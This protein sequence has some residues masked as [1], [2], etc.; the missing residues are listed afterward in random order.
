MLFNIK[1]YYDI[2]GTIVQRSIYQTKIRS[3]NNLPK[4]DPIRSAYESRRR[5]YS[6]ASLKVALNPDMTVFITLTYDPKRC[7]KDT[8]L[9]DLKNFFR[10]YRGAK[11][12]A[13]FEKHQKNPM[14]HIHLIT[15]IFPDVYVNENGYLS[16]SHW[17]RG[18][19]SVK[20]LNDFD[21][22]FRASKYVFKYITKGEKIKHKYVYS[23]RN[24]MTDPVYYEADLTYSGI[25]LALEGLQIVPNPVSLV[26]N[27]FKGVKR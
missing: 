14:Y 8:Y 23:S 26:Y 5:A 7:Q 6:L 21:D 11:Y 25:I 24:L 16:C 19:S 13:T 1:D 3:Y 10:H 17:H 2:S 12:L 18:F 27:T 4:H 9:D 22:S 20:Y 15:N